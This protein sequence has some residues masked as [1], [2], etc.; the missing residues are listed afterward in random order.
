MNRVLMV[1]DQVFLK[2]RFDSLSRTAHAS[3]DRSN[4]GKRASFSTESLVPGTV[5]GKWLPALTEPP[6]ALEEFVHLSAKTV[7]GIVAGYGIQ[8]PVVRDEPLVKLFPLRTTGTP[9]RSMSDTPGSFSVELRSWLLSEDRR[10]RESHDLTEAPRIGCVE[11]PM[12]SLE[13]PGLL[14]GTLHQR[15]LSFAKGLAESLAPLAPAATGLRHSGVRHK[16]D[17]RHRAGIGPRG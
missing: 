8:L 16:I 17:R 1:I 10:L 3:D 2:R 11:R 14:G 13:L 7:F 6:V 5:T 15:P 4:D 12:L 9:P